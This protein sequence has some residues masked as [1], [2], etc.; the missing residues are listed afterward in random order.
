VAPAERADDRR[1]AVLWP[2]APDGALARNKMCMHKIEEVWAIRARTEP[3][4][5]QQQHADRPCQLKYSRTCWLGLS[6]GRT[7]DPP[8]GGRR[9]GFRSRRSARPDPT[10]YRG[11]PVDRLKARLDDKR[12]KREQEDR[13]KGPPKK[14]EARG[15]CHSSPSVSCAGGAPGTAL[16][17]PTSTSLRKTPTKNKI[18]PWGRRG[19]G[20]GHCRQPGRGASSA[21]HGKTGARGEQERDEKRA[22]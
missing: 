7:A 8:H 9:R 14:G 4:S 16:C 1:A 15:R 11:W 22:S 13:E 3:Q 2:A 19:L 10:C 12:R 5:K 17:W 21:R 6:G 18:E 20:V